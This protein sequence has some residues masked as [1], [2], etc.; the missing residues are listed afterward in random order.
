[1]NERIYTRT[2]LLM[3]PFIIA[4]ALILYFVSDIDIAYSFV[5]GGVSSLLAMSYHYRGITRTMKNNPERIKFVTITNYLTRYLFYTLI[6]FIAYLKEDFSL[7]FVFIGL[8]SFKF[9]MMANI[10]LSRKVGDLE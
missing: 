7:T 1:M 4:I 8:I 6:L 5:L 10:L 9:V 2:F 3:W